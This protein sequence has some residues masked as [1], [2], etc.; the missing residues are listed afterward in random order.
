MKDLREAQ[1]MLFDKASTYTKLIF[2][3]AYGGFF[4]FWS[5]TKQ[6]LTPKQLVWSA[7]LVTVSLMLFVLFEVFNAAI[8]SHMAIRFAK[9]TNVP[10]ADLPASL[11]DFQRSSARL[12]KA[13]AVAWYPT[14]FL[15][16][17]SG[18]VGV[19][20]VLRGWVHWL[21]TTK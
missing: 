6:Y 16:L 15:S 12:T 17:S 4:A 13:L 14:F 10:V 18:L 21:Y 2:G 11:L 9:S 3:L 7:L 5:G 8:L 19:A 20:I 1:S